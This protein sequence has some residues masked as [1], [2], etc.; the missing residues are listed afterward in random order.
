MVEFLVFIVVVGFCVIIGFIAWIFCKISDW[1]YERKVNKQRKAFPELYIM[2]DNAYEI[3]KKVI[4]YRKKSRK[5]REEIKDI[6]TEM[7]YLIPSDKEKAERRLSD[8]RFDLKYNEED[9]VIPLEKASKTLWKEIRTKRE[10]YKKLGIK[11]L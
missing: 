10:D 6:L 3:D 4:E 2:L 9:N 8:L 7:S 1:N 11:I 5:I